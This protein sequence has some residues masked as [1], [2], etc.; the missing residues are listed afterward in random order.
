[1]LYSSSHL[2]PLQNLIPTVY[3]MITYPNENFEYRYPLII[4]T[5]ANN[6]SFCQNLISG[7]EADNIETCSL[8]L[9]A[10]ITIAADD[11]FCDIFSSFRQK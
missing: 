8:T 2:L 10:P 1:M 4:C 6:V 5:R 9:K 7:K 3:P 11:K